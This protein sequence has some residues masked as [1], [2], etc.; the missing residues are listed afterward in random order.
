MASVSKTG[1]GHEEDLFDERGIP[2]DEPSKLDDLTHREVLTLYQESGQNL[3][4]AKQQQWHTLG[5][6][7][8][9]SALIYGL[10]RLNVD[11]DKFVD[12]L[13]FGSMLFA[14]FAV[15]LLIFLQ[16]WQINEKK[17]MQAMVQ[18]FSPRTQWF[19]KQ[20]SRTESDVHRYI[21]LFMFMAYVAFVEIA[22]LRSLWNIPELS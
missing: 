3:L 9:I 6:F 17:K 12:F 4:F 18:D 10:T 8:I 1:S 13:F 20:K 2:Y 14:I 21:I 5:A 22:L 15:T 11:D 7:T 19:R 16:F